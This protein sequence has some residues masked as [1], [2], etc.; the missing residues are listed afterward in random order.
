[1][2]WESSSSEK[3]AAIEG[4]VFW[5]SGHSKKVALQ[6]KQDFRKC[7]SSEKADAVQKYLLRIKEVFCRYLYSKQL[8]HQKSSCS[9]K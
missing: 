8:L 1:M 5:K 6:E 3:V 7:S 2:F 4:N 9:E